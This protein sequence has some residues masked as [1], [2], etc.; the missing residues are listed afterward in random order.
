MIIWS[1]VLLQINFI[2]TASKSMVIFVAV[3]IGYNQYWQGGFMVLC[4]LCPGT[5]EGSTGSGSGFKAFQVMFN[6]Y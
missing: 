5:P 3:F 4:F 2:I 1:I 6:I